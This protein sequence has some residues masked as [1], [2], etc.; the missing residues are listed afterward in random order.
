M[1]RT[2]VILVALT[3]VA[4]CGGSGGAGGQLQV[5][6]STTILGDVVGTILG[7]RAAL[8][9][10][11]PVGADPHAFQ[12]SAA[13]A[14]R[15]RD[16]DLI[17]VNGL[18]L[19]EGLEAVIDG[20]ESDGV[21]VLEVAPLLRP[22]SREGGG[23]D[24]HVWFDPVR[25]ADAATL[26][27]EA[28]AEADPDRAEQWRHAASRYREELLELDDRIAAEVAAV[29]AERRLLVTTHDSLLY[30]AN[31]YGFRIVGVMVPG[32]STLAEPSAGDL[33][34]LIE[35]VGLLDVGA[36]FADATRPS[37]LALAL[38]DEAGDSVA[39]VTLYTGSL[40][41]P[42][43]GADTYPSMLLLDAERIIGALLP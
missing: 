39:V 22:L 15:L 41:E 29:P 33:A 42:G 36:I 20:A 34:D 12:A 13:Q 24:P 32:G 5:V 27:G 19:E 37:D 17:V 30:F 1:R 40:G 10:L 6:A 11:M 28:L 3:V 25:M 4:A 9:V 2:S 18:G 31:R 16:A 7:D 8:S 43:S 38:A 26:I 23:L 35:S 14:A 21:P